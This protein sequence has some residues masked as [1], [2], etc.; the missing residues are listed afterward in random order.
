[1]INGLTCRIGAVFGTISVVRDLLES[2]KSILILGKPGV[3]KTTIIREIARVLA[4]EMEKRV[5]IIDTSNEI[6]GDSDIPHSE[7]VGETDAGSKT[8]LQHQ[9][10]IEAVENHMPQVIIIDEIGTELEVLAARTIAEK[11]FNLLGR[12]NCLENLIKNPSLRNLFSITLSDD[13][14]NPKKYS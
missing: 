5:V 12:H 2:E 10:M 8:E 1:L 9:V 11:V 4:D 7:L 13:E 6:A 14:A 3:G